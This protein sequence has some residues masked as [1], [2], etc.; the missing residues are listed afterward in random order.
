MNGNGN[1]K[2]IALWAER[3]LPP[4]ED[5][6]LIYAEDVGEI[7][8]IDSDDNQIFFAAA[9]GDGNIYDNDGSLSGARTVDLN[10]NQLTM[11]NGD[12]LVETD[13]ADAYLAAIGDQVV[14]GGSDH[15]W[16]DTG[17]LQLGGPFS[18]GTPEIYFND[19]ANTGQ[20]VSANTGANVW[21]LPD[22][23][24]T[25]VVGSSEAYTPTN[26]TLDRAFDADTVAITE[27]AD[28][29]GTLI[30]DLQAV[31]LIQ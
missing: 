30:A 15:V 19:G 9:A 17:R 26:V 2:L 28:V 24:G 31:G 29:V 5:F 4:S 12:F 20:L 21:T 25:L 10:S 14:F 7:R 11:N 16:V 1:I 22:L 6:K 18:G 13:S 23:T 8:A 27:L 3:Q